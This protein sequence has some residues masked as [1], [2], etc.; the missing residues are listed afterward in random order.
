MFNV[1]NILTKIS[2]AGV[3]ASCD[4][5]CNVLVMFLLRQVDA[6]FETANNDI[7]AA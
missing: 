2:E 4:F 5:S 7:E 6:F 3:K 1:I